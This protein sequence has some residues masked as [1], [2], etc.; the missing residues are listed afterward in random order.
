M[1]AKTLTVIIAST[2]GWREK[3][4]LNFIACTAK[5]KGWRPRPKI[6]STTTIKF[7]NDFSSFG[8]IDV[9][10]QIFEKFCS[11]LGVVQIFKA[12]SCFGRIGIFERGYSCFG[13]IDIQQN[14]REENLTGNLLDHSNVGV[15]KKEEFFKCIPKSWE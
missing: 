7:F 5:C 6:V 3:F 2:S 10:E 1:T 14:E 15:I 9:F 8:R 13:R 4:Y 12:F 11:C